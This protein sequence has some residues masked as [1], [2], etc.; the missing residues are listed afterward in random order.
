VAVVIVEAIGQRGSLPVWLGPVLVVAGV[1]AAVG[2]VLLWRE[3]L[4]GIRER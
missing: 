1:A 2:A 4:A 3:Y